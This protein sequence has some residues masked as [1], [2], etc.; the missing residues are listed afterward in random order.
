LGGL[1][2]TFRGN[3]YY[4]KQNKVEKLNAIL[5]LLDEIETQVRSLSSEE[6]EGSRN[7]IPSRIHDVFKDKPLK[8][9]KDSERLVEEEQ[10]THFVSS[11]DWFAF[12]SLYGT[13]EE[14]AFVRMLDR[15]ME[16]LRPHYDDIYLI[17][18]E[19]HFS[20][21]N[22]SD[23]KTFQPDFVLFL[24]EKDGQSLTYQLFIEP[25]GAHL[26]EHDRWKEEFLKEIREEFGDKILTFGGESKY[27]LIGIPF[28][29][30]EDENAF[31]ETLDLALLK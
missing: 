14:R 12:D 11:K 15:Q 19:G 16:K 2:I 13:S 28:Y 7:F 18:N 24:K 22:F 5:S 8:L 21:Y 10:I 31:R 4:L 29:N 1:E 6:L 30:N 3:I 20:I 23:G 27:R 25:K 17:R 9:S 26:T